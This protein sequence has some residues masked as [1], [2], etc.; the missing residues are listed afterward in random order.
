MSPQRNLLD[1]RNVLKIRQEQ[2][3]IVVENRNLI[4]KKETKVRVIL[5]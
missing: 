1:L 5:I 3:F 4:F 2:D